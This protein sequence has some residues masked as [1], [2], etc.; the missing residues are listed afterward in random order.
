[1]DFRNLLSHGYD[2]VIPERVWSYANH[3]LPEFLRT[4]SAL[5][6][7][8]GPPDATHER[9]APALTLRPVSG[10]PDAVNFLRR[11]NLD[12]AVRETLVEQ[13]PTNEPAAELL[14]RCAAACQEKQLHG[15]GM[16]QMS[17]LEAR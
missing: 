8:L 4:V 1:M 16:Q 17:R 6:T 15:S 11:L 13:D 9:T 10:A 2:R 7:E 5:L 3:D 12:I 14:K